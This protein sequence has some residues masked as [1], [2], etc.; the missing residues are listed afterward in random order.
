MTVNKRKKN[1]RM[2][3]SSTHGWGS[4]KK[5]RGAG[6]RGGKGMAGSGKRADQKKPT[7][8]KLYGNDYYGKRGFH[9]PQK[10]IK[11]IR[12]IN[13]KD[14]Q[15]HIE[16]YVKDKLAEKQGNTYVVDLSKL[17]Y[18]K[19]LGGGHVNIKL[20]IKADQFSKNAIHKIE[21]NGGEIIREDV[22]NK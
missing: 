1:S 7:I 10:L 12:T 21:E 3:A 5:H 11:K 6:H 4:K 13:L 2:R 15:K 19:L 14:L 20:K 22:N 18:D 9:R 16:S 8:L 17:G